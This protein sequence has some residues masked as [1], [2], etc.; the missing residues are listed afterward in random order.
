MDANEA[1][2]LKELEDENRPLKRKRHAT[3]TV[4]ETLANHES[5]RKCSGSTP[6]PCPGRLETVLARA[7]SGLPRPTT[8]SCSLRPD[9]CPG[10]NSGS[11]TSGRQSR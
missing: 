10:T 8:R 7:S 4:E 11:S 2:R 9:F 1:K 6:R 3:L 5:R